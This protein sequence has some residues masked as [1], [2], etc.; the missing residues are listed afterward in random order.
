MNPGSKNLHQIPWKVVFANVNIK[1][2]VYKFVYFR[3]GC[4]RLRQSVRWSDGSVDGVASAVEDHRFRLDHRQHDYSTFHSGAVEEERSACRYRCRR[5]RGSMSVGH[6]NDVAH[7]RGKS[8]CAL[9]SN[10]ASPHQSL[11]VR[12]A[13]DECAAAA[14]GRRRRRRCAGGCG[15]PSPGIDRGPALAGAGATRNLASDIVMETVCRCC[16]PNDAITVA[17]F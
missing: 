13:R 11:E 12:C 10:S 6:G 7:G 8:R 16:R 4:E 3:L 5:P 9:H 2:D 1:E 15:F 17:E 14:S